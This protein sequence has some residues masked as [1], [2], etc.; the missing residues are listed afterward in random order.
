MSAL[1]TRVKVIFVAFNLMSVG[2][3]F[4]GGYTSRVALASIERMQCDSAVKV[5]NR[6]SIDIN[7]QAARAKALADVQRA[8]LR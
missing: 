6:I 5:A 7:H 2:V 8:C 4:V 3:G 1:N